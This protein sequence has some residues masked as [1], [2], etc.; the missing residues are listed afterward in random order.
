MKSN[1]KYFNADEIKAKLGDEPW[2]EETVLF[3]YMKNYEAMN[4]IFKILK[5]IKYTQN[6]RIYE[7]ITK[8][9]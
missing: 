2:N 9:K 7:F 1:E 6:F 8:R 5:D 4:T 3:L